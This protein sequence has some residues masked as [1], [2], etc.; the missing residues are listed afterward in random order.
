M[1]PVSKQSIERLYH[2]WKHTFVSNF[3]PTTAYGRKIKEDESLTKQAME[4]T[5]LAL[6]S[7][8]RFIDEQWDTWFITG[9]DFFG[10]LLD[11]MDRCEAQNERLRKRL[12]KLN[13]K[14]KKKENE[15]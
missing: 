9:D 1:Y 11:K 7:F 13:E 5:S 4:F 10:I 8:I 15:K 6:S 3:Y 12:K 14:N 2:Q